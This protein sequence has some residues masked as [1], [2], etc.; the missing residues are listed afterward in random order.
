MASNCGGKAG[1]ALAPGRAPGASIDSL[2]QAHPVLSGSAALLVTAGGTFGGIKW[3][4]RRG[5]EAQQLAYVQ[6]AQSQEI[7]RYQ[8]NGPAEFEHALAFLCARGWMHPRAGCWS[9]GRP[10]SGRYR[11]RARWSQDRA[12]SQALR[13][14]DESRRPRPATVRGDLLPRPPCR[15]RGRGHDVHVHQTGQ[16]VRHPHG[17]PASRCARTRRAGKPNWTGA[18]AHG[19]ESGARWERPMSNHLV[20]DKPTVVRT[21]HETP[22]AIA[23]VPI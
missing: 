3:K 8:R 16:R 7:A 14:N 9:C 20:D 1:A 22:E 19:G 17:R 23:N 5:L 13:A 21:V 2:V 18:V 15:G 4:R 10:G 12:T 6:V 11:L